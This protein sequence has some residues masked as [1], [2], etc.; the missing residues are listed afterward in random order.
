MEGIQ[1]SAALYGGIGMTLFGMLPAFFAKERLYELN[2]KEH[3]GKKDPF[4]QSAKTTLQ[5]HAFRIL[6]TLAVFTIIAG[7]FAST[8]DWYLLTF[9][10]SDGDISLGTQW[11]LVVTV[12]YAT[13]GVLGIP[14]IVWLTGK[15][16]K[17]HGLMF[18][19][20]MMILNAV[21][22]WFVY[23]PGR[24]GTSL[25]WGSFAEAGSSLAAIGQS[26]IWLDPLTGGMF[27][28]G[29]GVLGQSLIADVCDDDEIK[30]GRRREGMFGAIYGWS[31]KASFALSF[32]LIGFFLEGIGF[33]P[34]WG[35]TRWMSVKANADQY[36]STK[37]EFAIADDD[38]AKL[39]VQFEKDWLVVEEASQVKMTVSCSEPVT[40]DL[41]VR[42]KTKKSAVL[43]L[44]RFITIPAH[45]QSTSITVPLKPGKKMFT[46]VQVAASS[47]GLDVAKAEL[48]VLSGGNEATVP[49]LSGLS[50]DKGMIDESN[51]SALATVSREDLKGDLTV[52]LKSS[53][54]NV[55]IPKTVI[56][57]DGEK[58][59]E[60]EVG[61][62]NDRKKR[63]VRSATITAWVEGAKPV[64]ST[65]SVIDDDGPA[66][67]AQLDG[68]EVSENGG[69][70]TGTLTR[71]N[72]TKGDA[73]VSLEGF[74]SAIKPKNMV[75]TV[76]L[77]RTVTIPD[78][79]ESVSFAIAAV[80]NNRAD[81]QQT[82]K[83]FFN[84]RIAMCAGAAG[85]ALLCF[86]LLAFY[87]LSKEK[88]EENRRK[89]EELRRKTGSQE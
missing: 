2:V 66:L 60:F 9:Y 67:S 3:K 5:N 77:P 84:M 69:E 30:N 81:G 16:T 33:D 26:L 85:P 89:L 8:M 68:Y 43:D 39:S 14:F 12:G 61:A 86:I 36:R 42:L 40:E 46:A 56:I 44:P 59:V 23:R 82:E 51:G 10:L 54:A 19:Y 64:R 21:M 52:K 87:P 73:V 15:M 29:V 6:C 80:D 65:V 38:A 57:P 75:A 72:N 31:N 18:I 32:V 78:G 34:Q 45:S 48:V 37:A 50:M 1:R 70:L 47:P 27:W 20:G 53:G 13:V 83:T 11:K 62:V 4:W 55:R 76:T 7:V 22:R 49:V 58:S 88:A 17:I 24:F 63:G 35:S 28:I 79:A 41:V 25:S 74:C 71:Y